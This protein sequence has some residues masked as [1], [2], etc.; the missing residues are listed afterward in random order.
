MLKDRVVIVVQANTMYMMLN[1][2]EMK[3]EQW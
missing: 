2:V 3:T 1:L